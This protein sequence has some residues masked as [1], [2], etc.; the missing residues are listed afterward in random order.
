M[1]DAGKLSSQEQ[2]YSGLSFRLLQK[3]AAYTDLI[4]ISSDLSYR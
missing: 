1:Y 3:T 4:F 2:P